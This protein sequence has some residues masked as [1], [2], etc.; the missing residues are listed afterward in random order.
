M[1]IPFVVGQ[2]LVVNGW[3]LVDDGLLWIVICGSWRGGYA[4]TCYVD[5]LWSTNV[6]SWYVHGG[7]G[8]TCWLNG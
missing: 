8:Q 3:W 6:N 7:S 1:R 5:N 2:G 4:D